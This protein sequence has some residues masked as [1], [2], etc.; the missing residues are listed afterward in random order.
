MRRGTD[1]N[2]DKSEEDVLK[3]YIKATNPDFDSEDVNEEYKERYT[4]DDFSFD[5]SKLKRENDNEKGDPDFRPGHYFIPGFCSSPGSADR[6]FPR[7]LLYGSG[8][9]L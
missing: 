9:G 1:P 2:Q 7:P 6:F 5:D 3:A 4:I 8:R